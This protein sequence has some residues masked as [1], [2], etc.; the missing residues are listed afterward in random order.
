MNLNEQGQ[1]YDFVAIGGDVPDY[2]VLSTAARQQYGSLQ[3]FLDTESVG[4]DHS[5]KA[6]LLEIGGCLSKLSSALFQISRL[7]F[8]HDELVQSALTNFRGKGP[9]ALATVNLPAL[10]DFESLLFHGRAA[11]DRTTLF[12][13]REFKQY[14]CSRYSRLRNVL[15]DFKDKDQ[16]AQELITILDE[17]PTMPGI[18]VDRKSVV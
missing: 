1:Q 15:G 12:I 17:S 13:S 4:A 9:G 14:N 3:Q 10:T 7:R 6:W 11:L 8:Y 16:R 5:R 2:G 18:F